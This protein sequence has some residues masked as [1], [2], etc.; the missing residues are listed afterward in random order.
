MGP[1]DVLKGSPISDA[2]GFVDTNKDT[3]QHKK[4]RN[5]FGIGD[6]TNLPISKTAA[7]VA[8]Q[9]KALRRNIMEIVQGRSPEAKVNIVNYRIV[10]M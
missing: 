4:Y 10:S 5:I 2:N 3:M 9:S 8:G 6:C 7:A 1:P